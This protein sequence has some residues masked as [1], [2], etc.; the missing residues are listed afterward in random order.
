M[1]I[2]GEKINTTRKSMGRAVEERDH[3]AVQ[4]EALRQVQAGAHMIDVNCGSLS[5]DAEP[6]TLAWLV[7]TVQS[8]VDVPLCVDSPNPHAL[9]RA[10]AVHRGKPMINSISGERARY[11]QVLPMVKQYGASV[12]ALGMDDRGIPQNK[13][14]AREVGVTLVERL[15]GDGIS[16]DDI[17]F[18]PLVR[19][20][21]TN[22]QAV[23]EC[24][25]LMQEL[26]S[27]FARLHFVS[28][29]SNVS[30][31]LPERRHL[32]RAFV[33]MSIANGLDTVIMDPLDSTMMALILA[34]EALMNK[35]R[36]CMNYIKA[37]NQGKLKETK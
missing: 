9:T 20:V 24:L 28:G 8:S 25:Q 15:L 1:L 2:I 23:V 31:G 33:V 29:L 21:A 13:D 12:V 18:D 3:R 6:E 4:E 17:Y 7:D 16:L 14:Q 5:A 32:N 34:A 26:R 22:Q 36:F 30:F 19:S 10:L 11:E 27:R 35:D 37:Y